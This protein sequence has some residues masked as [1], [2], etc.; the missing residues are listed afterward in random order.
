MA[1]TSR[2][3]VLG[4]LGIDAR[5]GV[6][7]SPVRRVVLGVRRGRLALVCQGIRHEVVAWRASM[8]LELRGKHK[9]D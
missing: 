1:L 3:G 9:Y 6:R 2:R 8:R 7:V 5:V 4:E